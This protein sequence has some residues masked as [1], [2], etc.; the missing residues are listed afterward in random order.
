MAVEALTRLPLTVILSCELV[1]LSPFR[2]NMEGVHKGIELA[3]QQVSD[4]R[5]VVC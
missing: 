3:K 4:Q 2:G 5:C 1:K